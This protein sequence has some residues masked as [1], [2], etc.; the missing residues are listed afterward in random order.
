M[1][2]TSY[3]FGDFTLDLAERQLLRDDR[4]V[5][6]TV[7]AFDVL[8]L[9]VEHAGRT[10][11]KEEFMDTV[12]T[13]TVVEEANLTDNIS[14]L[15]Q[16]LGDDAREPRYI[17]TVPK[18]GYRFVA[19]VTGGAAVASPALSAV[20]G[21]AGESTLSAVE[22][23]AAPPLRRGV[24]GTIIAAIVLLTLAGVAFRMG[25]RGHGPQTL[26]VLPFKPLVS[27][28]RDSAME[29]GM[30]DALIAKLSRIDELRVRPT[31]AVMPFAD[32]AADFR[33]V[34]EQLD[35]DTIL[36]GKIQKS[37]DRVRV[38]VQLVRT[39]DGSTI[40]AERFDERFTDIFALQDAISERVANALQV[41]LTQQQRQS[42]NEDATDNVEAYHLYLNGLHHWRAF[43]PES[44]MA[45]V[46][47]HNAALQLDPDFALAWAGLARAYMVIAIYGPLPA[48]E[49]FPKARE[50]ALKGVALAPN[51]A[52]TH[53][54]MAAVKLF[55]DRDWRGAQRELD[56][57]EQLDPASG[58]LATL[59]GYYYQ[60]MGRPD[61][62]LGLLLKSRD[63]APDWQITTS[64]VLEGLI[65]ARR[66]DEA[67][68]ESRRQIALDPRTATPHSVLGSALAATG[69]FDEAI[70]PLEEAVKHSQKTAVR[71]QGTLAWTHAKAGRREQALA[72]IEEM[73]RSDSPWMPFSVARAYT[74]LG[75][76]DQVFV[77]L[78][79]A[80]DAHFA[81]LWDV[82]NRYEFDVIRDDPRYAQLLARIRL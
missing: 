1:T 62:A 40:W 46:N 48:S 43:T 8:L 57:M 67:I 36:D 18:R 80:A 54:P 73:K 76:Q 13:G 19:P 15:R 47:Y 2:R 66:F 29:I 44:L 25:R 28:D 58:D 63:A 30:A 49:A 53:V 33:E 23:T 26:A 55:H 11:T 10:V 70:A 60:A 39:G 45:A 75:E 77:W 50:A 31:T 16:A 24:A 74:A 20:E 14:T 52:A 9:L 37:G 21:P 3:R 68:R 17:R 71:H 5:P 56:L 78:N 81:F 61:L 82:R 79:R 7:R 41:R 42:L 59:R 12:W 34:A 22:A 72:L 69:R 35:V 6:L 32:G 64:D 65:E 27:A 51:T 38:S 4:V